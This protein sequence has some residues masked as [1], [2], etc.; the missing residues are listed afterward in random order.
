MPPVSFMLFARPLQVLLEAEFEEYIA[1]FDEATEANKVGRGALSS[2]GGVK[3]G[4]QGAVVAHFSV[5]SAS[6]KGDTFMRIFRITTGPSPAR[7]VPGSSMR[8]KTASSG[9]TGGR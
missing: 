3:P 7:S 2:S 5:S 4:N 8:P 9:T 6:G 1:T